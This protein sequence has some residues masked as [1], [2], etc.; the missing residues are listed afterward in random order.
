[1]INVSLYIVQIISFKLKLCYFS[2]KIKV[3]NY[4]LGGADNMGHYIF[5]AFREHENRWYIF[6]DLCTTALPIKENQWIMS[7]MLLYT[8]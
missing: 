3:Q 6:D 4:L 1:M 2:N 7:E 5:N 8:I